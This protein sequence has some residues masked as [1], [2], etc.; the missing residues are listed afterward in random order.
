MD[1]IG[2]KKAMG[3]KNISLA[4]FLTF[5]DKD[6]F[7]KTQL[8]YRFIQEIKRQKYDMYKRAIASTSGNHVII[9]DYITGQKKEMIMMGSNNFLGLANHPKVVEATMKAVEKYGL[10]STGAPLL[11]GTFA[12]HCELEQRL[13]KLKGCEDAVLFTSGYSANM[14]TLT[15]L[16][17]HK[18]V[19]I[20]DRLNHAS[21]IDGC[22]LSGAVVEI[23]KHN[24]I[25]H[26]ETILRYADER[27]DGKLVVVDGVY[28]MDGDTAPLAQIVELAKRYK[29]YT[30]V[31]EAHATGVIGPQGRGTLA[32]YNVE[33]S[34]DLVMITFSK[35]LGCQGA[36]VAS[37]KEVCEYL[38][39]FSRSTFFST[40]L[41][42]AI[43]AGVLAALDVLESEPERRKRLWENID[44][45]LK[46]L[47][48]MGYK[49]ANTQSAIIPVIIGDDEKLRKM[50]VK[51]HEA[52][53]FVGV[54]PYPAV[55][56]GQARFR[57]T[58][59]ATHTKEDLDRALDVFKKVGKK[60]GVLN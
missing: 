53:I 26:L 46:N 15:A 60:L 29:A 54:I 10:G 32:Y 7:T 50:S 35:A 42:P 9:D 41:P 37:T 30:M 23:F 18:D 19:A 47:K 31:D 8:F 2:F 43:A 28:S 25:V 51:I 16:L 55:P 48:A 52:G 13:A 36:A 57:V 49:I 21:I 17:A 3:I 1:T 4:T 45:M 14:G 20:N 34:V 33:G 56:R 22:R 40:H 59:M 6:L 5:H 44:Y 58:A 38:R 27:Y 11:S 39:F 12:V 24:D